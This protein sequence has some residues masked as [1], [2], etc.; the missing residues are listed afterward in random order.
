VLN[1]ESVLECNVDVMARLHVDVPDALH[2]G[3]VILRIVGT[4]YLPALCVN[5]SAAPW[6]KKVKVNRI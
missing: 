4:R 1:A 5:H 2:T 6:V 3:M